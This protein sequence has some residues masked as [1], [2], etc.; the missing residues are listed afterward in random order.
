MVHLKPLIT[1][2]CAHIL[3]FW[4]LWRE[5]AALNQSWPG[6]PPRPLPSPS[7][8]PSPLPPFDFALAH[9]VSTVMDSSLNPCDD[10]FAYACGGWL[11][12]AVIPPDRSRYRLSCEIMH[13]STCSYVRMCVFQAMIMCRRFIIHHIHIVNRWERS[14]SEIDKRNEQVLLNIVQQQWPVIS[15][16]FDNCMDEATINLLGVWHVSLINLMEF[17]NILI[18][19][20]EPHPYNRCLQKSMTQPP[21]SCMYVLNVFMLNAVLIQL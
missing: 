16:F 13:C 4:H 5:V 7:P 3:I 6:P 19:L 14:F 17:Q 11:E 21:T 20:Q 15:T 1:N 12:T 8:S 2:V 10:F 9:E 18:P